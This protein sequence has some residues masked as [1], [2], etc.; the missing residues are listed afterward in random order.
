MCLP[1]LTSYLLF[2]LFTMPQSLWVSFSPAMCHL[3]FFVFDLLFTLNLLPTS[4]HVSSFFECLCKA[5]PIGPSKCYSILSK[6]THL[7][8]YLCWDAIW[9]YVWHI[10]SFSQYQSYLVSNTYSVNFLSKFIG[11][12]VAEALAFSKM[13]KTFNWLNLSL[14]LFLCHSCAIFRAL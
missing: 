8:Q 11:S 1:D 4:L 3:F 7:L 10:C 13:L 12:D 9:M 2:S 14:G 6:D 5:F